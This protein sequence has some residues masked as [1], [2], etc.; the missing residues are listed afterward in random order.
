MIIDGDCIEVM[1]TL[2]DNS[3]DAVV[4]DPP[5][6]IEFMGKKW[7]KHESPLAF[8]QWCQ[9]WATQA[10]RVLKPGG[11]LLAFGGTRTY[12]RLACGIEDAGFEVRDSIHWIYSSGFPKSHNVSKT[13]DRMAGAERE[14]VATR[15]LTGNGKTMKSGFHQP[16]GTGAGETVKQEIFEI[17]APA[18]P[19]AQKWDGWGTALKP[20]HEPVIVA[21]KPL[22]GTVAANVLEYGTGAYNIDGCRVGMNVLSSEQSSQGRWPA[23]I[24]LSHSENCVEVGSATVKGRSSI[25]RFTDGAKPFGGGAGH[26]FTSEQFPDETIPVW[27]CAEGCP[28]AEMDKQSGI[29]KG[30]VGMKKT[31]GGHRFIVGDTESVQKFDHGTT[32]IGGASRFF[33]CAKAN[34]KE[35]NIGIPE[36]ESNPHPTVKPI[37]L[38]RYLCRLVTPPGGIVLDPFAG[39]GSCGIAA[40]Q[41]GFDYIGIEITPEYVEIAEKRI[42]HALASL[43]DR[44]QSLF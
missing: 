42:T 25:N 27:D 38:M 7:D 30:Q 13:I 31:H 44:P 39:S 20:A 23:N 33:Y 4:C 16:D 24:I 12:H 43:E 8:Q 34:K 35:R 29:V 2:G 18:T 14:V 37:A 15:P 3:V 21:R 40:V 6:S 36:G 17:T 5:Y 19:D 26:E 11:H 41:E 28:V 10:L 32:D 9:E 1:A 22:I